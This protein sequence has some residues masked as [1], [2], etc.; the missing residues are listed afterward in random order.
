MLRPIVLTVT[1]LMFL[2]SAGTWRSASGADV[3]WPGWLGP[4]R[5]GWVIGFKPPPR[6]AVG[7]VRGWQVD[8]GSG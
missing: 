6:W 7:Q 5:D 4:K 1:A 8:V 2:Q 3:H